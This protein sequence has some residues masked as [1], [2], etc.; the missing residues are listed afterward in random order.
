MDITLGERR[1][2]KWND[3]NGRS[4]IVI[5]KLEYVTG[6]NQFQSLKRGEAMTIKCD[7][8]GAVLT[9]KQA[10]LEE[11]CSHCR[12]AG[13]YPDNPLACAYCGGTGETPTPDPSADCLPGYEAVELRTNV[14]C[15]FLKDRTTSVLMSS[16]INMVGFSGRYGYKYKGYE[17]E[18]KV[19]WSRFSRN[20]KNKE[21]EMSEE[22]RESIY[23]DHSRHNIPVLPDYVEM[24]KDTDQ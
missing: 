11:V 18:D 1:G 7:K 16:V 15:L 4:G 13:V 19:F 8:C 10:T 17:R 6:R 12:G 20:Y 21:G 22:V 3:G 9:P 5:M 23:L 24:K 14:E 2:N